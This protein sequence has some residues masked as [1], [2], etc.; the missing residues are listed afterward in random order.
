MSNR[1]VIIPQLEK[2]FKHLNKGGL[3]FSQKENQGNYKALIEEREGLISQY[4]QWKEQFVFIY[5]E[6]GGKQC[7]II[8]EPDLLHQVPDGCR[9]IVARCIPSKP[10]SES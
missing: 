10:D 7:R 3:E 2:E 1:N 5:W 9:I 6:Y 8:K 4:P